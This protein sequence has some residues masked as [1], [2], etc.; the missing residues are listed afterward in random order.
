MQGLLKAN[1]GMDWAVW[2]ELVDWN[3]RNRGDGERFPEEEETGIVIAVAEEWL[4]REE[5][6]VL[7]EI[8]ERVVALKE[9]LEGKA[10]LELE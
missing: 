5:A 4:G 6:C 9:F 8:R 2:W 3:V 7:G 1:W 10:A